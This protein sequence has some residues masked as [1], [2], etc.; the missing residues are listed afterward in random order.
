VTVVLELLV[1][2]NLLSQGK[3]IRKL[4]SELEF[5][6]LW[7]ANSITHLSRFFAGLIPFSGIIETTNKTR[8]QGK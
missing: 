6:C 1:S 2:E 4:I 5:D 8:G 3:Q 7:Q